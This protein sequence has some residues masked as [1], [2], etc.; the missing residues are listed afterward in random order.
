MTHVSM[1][2]DLLTHITRPDM[3][4][5]SV[6]QLMPAGLGWSGLGWSGLGC[7]GFGLTFASSSEVGRRVIDSSRFHVVSSTFPVASSPRLAWNPRTDAVVLL[8]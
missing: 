6:S 8:P 7:S 3:H 4:R 2:V 5:A 1:L